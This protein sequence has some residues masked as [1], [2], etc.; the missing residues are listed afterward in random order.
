MIAT[1]TETVFSV[2]RPYTVLDVPSR[3]RLRENTDMA[4]GA[5]LARLRNGKNWTQADLAERIGVQQPTIQRWEAEGRQP[6]RASLAKLAKVLGVE[7]AELFDAAEDNLTPSPEE[8]ADM[9]AR[10]MRELPVGVSYE[11]Y[12]T[13]VSASLHDQ[14]KQ[15][16]VGGGFRHTSDEVSVPGKVARPQ[17]P[18]RRSDPEEPH[19]P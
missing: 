15:F 3:D 9:I 8:L 17:R 13:A 19:N 11:D 2:N 1:Y 12:P 5:K 18:T 7:V 16:R 4:F 6:R 14:L 10:A